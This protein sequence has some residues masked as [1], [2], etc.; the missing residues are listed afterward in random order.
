MVQNKFIIYYQHNTREFLVERLSHA[1]YRDYNT[2]IVLI[3]FVCACR[4]MSTANNLFLVVVMPLYQ[5]CMGAGTCMV[6]H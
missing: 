5:S 6:H 4:T 2:Y 1:D 3:C